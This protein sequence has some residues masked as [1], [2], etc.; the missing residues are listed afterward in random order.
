MIYQLIHLKELFLVVMQLVIYQYHMF[1]K[2][3][4]QKFL[5]YIIVV[6]LHLQQEKYKGEWTHLALCR[7]NGT[8]RVFINGELQGSGLIQQI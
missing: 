3:Q 4:H 6:L 8:S 5:V 7:E 2:Y 1:I